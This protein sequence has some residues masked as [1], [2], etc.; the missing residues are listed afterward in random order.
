[1]IP[2]PPPPPLSEGG[3]GALGGVNVNVTDVL[4]ALP[5]LSFTCST[6]VFDPE[7]AVIVVLWQLIR[8]VEMPFR[9]YQHLSM[10]ML[11]PTVYFRSIK[12][13]E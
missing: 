3:G 9:T 2:L 11:S 10:I 13:D 6:R 12:D 5:E 1:M 7:A 8:S 4:F